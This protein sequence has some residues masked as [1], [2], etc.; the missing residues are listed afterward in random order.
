MNYLSFRVWPLDLFC[1]TWCFLA[2]AKF[3]FSP[4]ILN[5]QFSYSYQF[6]CHWL[7][8]LLVSFWLMFILYILDFTQ[9]CIVPYNRQVFIKIN[10]LLQISL[11]IYFEILDIKFI[12][13]HF[14]TFWSSFESNCA[15]GLV[16]IRYFSLWRI[17]D[18]PFSSV[19]NV[20]PF[21]TI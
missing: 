18:F 19:V 11:Y 12:A 20:Y 9:V 2:T 3:E 10:C 15:I 17:G 8:V 5:P 14:S 16:F 1:L 13:C 7:T 21:L 4:S 6:C